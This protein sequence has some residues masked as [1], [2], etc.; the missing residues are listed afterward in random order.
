M[1]LLGPLPLLMNS[2]KLVIQLLFISWKNSFSDVSRKTILPS[3]IR[4]IR[5]DIIDF[6]LLGSSPCAF[7]RVG[8]QD[9]KK[10]P[11]SQ[12][13]FFGP[14][15]NFHQSVGRKKKK[16]CFAGCNNTLC[17]SR[18]VGSRD[19]WDKSKLWCETGQPLLSIVHIAYG[20]ISVFFFTFWKILTF[21]LLNLTTMY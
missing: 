3:M 17:K 18:G 2:M 4:L 16:L 7:C 19:S 9:E 12:F 21:C 14:K 15:W 10:N 5:S 13:L 8:R 1:A 6:Y 11:K 20:K